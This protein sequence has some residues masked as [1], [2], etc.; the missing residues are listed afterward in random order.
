MRTTIL[1][2]ASV[3]AFIAPCAAQPHDAAPAV[4]SA[5]ARPGEALI[6]HYYYNEGVLIRRPICKTEHE[7][8]RVR[9]RE[10]ADISD[11]QLRALRGT[12]H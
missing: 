4:E 6:C 1:T 10:Q 2:L 8:I 12:D 3:M 11:F 5:G 9:L 7:W